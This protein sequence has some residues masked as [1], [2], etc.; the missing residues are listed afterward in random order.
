MRESSGHVG[1]SSSTLDTNSRKMSCCSWRP[2]LL[3]YPTSS[4]GEWFSHGRIKQWACTKGMKREALILQGLGSLCALSA[5]WT[6]QEQP[7][8]QTL[9]RT[10][11][12]TLTEFWILFFFRKWNWEDKMDIWYL[13]RFLVINSGIDGMSLENCDFSFKFGLLPE[14]TLKQVRICIHMWVCISYQLCVL[15]RYLRN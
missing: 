12:S 15:F 9:K 5:D 11:K 1:N 7:K 3:I 13:V 10:L 6:T 14:F 8:E 4:S 2:T